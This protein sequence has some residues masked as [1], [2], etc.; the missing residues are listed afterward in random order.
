MAKASTIQTDAPTGPHHRASLAVV[1]H[2]QLASDPQLNRCTTPS[3]LLAASRPAAAGES[4][5][6]GGERALQLQRRLLEVALGA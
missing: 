4:V 3:R 6:A 5:D 1:E 2:S